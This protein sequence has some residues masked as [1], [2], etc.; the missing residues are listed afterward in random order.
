LQDILAELFR[1]SLDI[2]PLDAAAALKDLPEDSVRG[3]PEEVGGLH[4]SEAEAGIGPIGSHRVHRLVVGHPR[5]GS[6]HLDPADRKHPDQQLFD[7]IIPKS[8]IDKGGLQI[9]LREL[10]LPVGPKVLV[11]EA[12]DDLEVPFEAAD[13][14]K[15][16]E[17]LGRLG[18]R[19]EASRMQPAGDQV[20]PGAFRG[21][22]C[23]HGRFNL[24]ET[25]LVEE[26]PRDLDDAVT[27]DEAILHGRTPQVEVAVLEPDL[28]GGRI[29]PPGG[30]A[31]DHRLFRNGEGQG[32]GPAQDLQFGGRD[33]D[34][35]RFDVGIF[36]ARVTLPDP[37]PKG[38]A[39][40][41]SQGGGGLAELRIGEFRTEDDLNHAAAVAQ[42]DEEQLPVIPQ[43]I[44]PTGQQ[45]LP[46]NVGEPKAGA[47]DS[48]LM[49]HGIILVETVF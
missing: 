38:N 22:F 12:A 44:H 17:K 32:F 1:L 8:L 7:Q 13:H 10:R 27:L 24:Q 6:G 15:L 36:G 31:G 43:G 41:V 18:Q 21:A 39:K 45:N 2:D 5:K 25:P 3:V 20:V 30:G 37:P 33:L 35:A 11:A 40:L 47:G 14:E 34:E 23:Q 16:L 46:V 26:V 19:V 48:F 28:F 29:G 42:V 4:E 9:E 49:I